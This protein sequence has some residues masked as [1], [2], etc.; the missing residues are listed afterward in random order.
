VLAT[1]GIEVHEIPG[2][3]FNIIKEPHVA[4]LA[5]KLTDCLARVQGRHLHVRE[6][7]RD[8]YVITRATKMRAA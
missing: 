5:R 4:E 8:D 2:N 7:A 1:G 3:H 6:S